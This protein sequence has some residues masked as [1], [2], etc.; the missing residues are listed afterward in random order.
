MDISEDVNNAEAERASLSN[1][2][3][4]NFGEQSEQNESFRIE[5]QVY[6]YVVLAQSSSTLYMNI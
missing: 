4:Q 3:L 2:V 5:Y 1:E 6:E